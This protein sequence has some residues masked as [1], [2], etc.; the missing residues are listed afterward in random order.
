MRFVIQ[1]VSQADV[2]IDG[3]IKGSIQQG[4]MNISFVN[5]GNR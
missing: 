5:A 2:K 3:N 4:F 1:V